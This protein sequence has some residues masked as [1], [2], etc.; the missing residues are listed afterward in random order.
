MDD[1]EAVPLGNVS[2]SLIKGNFIKLKEVSWNY[3]KCDEIKENVIKLKKMSW[4]F[5]N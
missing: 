1:I 4:N 5:F 2:T 3:R